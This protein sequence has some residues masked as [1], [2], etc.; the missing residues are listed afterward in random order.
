[1]IEYHAAVGVTHFQSE[2]G[3]VFEVRQMIAG[4]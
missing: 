3:G 4:E 1:M 2:R